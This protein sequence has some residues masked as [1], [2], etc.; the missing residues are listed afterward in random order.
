[1]AYAADFIA[2]YVA[3]IQE[4]SALPSHPRI[5]VSLPPTMY[6]LSQQKAGWPTP[7]SAATRYISLVRSASMSTG[8]CFLKT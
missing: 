3:L 8:T 1:M 6:V 7:V 4:F 5:F 2:D